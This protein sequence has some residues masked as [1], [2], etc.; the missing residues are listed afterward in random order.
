MLIC[1]IAKKNL[2]CKFNCFYKLFKNIKLLNEGFLVLMLHQI[3][4]VE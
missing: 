3:F 1:S 2:N 4:K